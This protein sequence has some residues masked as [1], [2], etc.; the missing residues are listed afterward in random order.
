MLPSHAPTDLQTLTRRDLEELA[1]AL[2]YT[3]TVLQRQKRSRSRGP[4]K[5]DNETIGHIFAE[6]IAI[7]WSLADVAEAARTSENRVRVKADYYTRFV[8][9]SRAESDLLR[10]SAS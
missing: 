6:A 5:G 8:A 9:P 1:V 10:R 3:P 2:G 4:F 7:G